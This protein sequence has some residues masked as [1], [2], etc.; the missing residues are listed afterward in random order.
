[1]NLSTCGRSIES[2]KC[3]EAPLSTIRE[4]QVPPLQLDDA[5]NTFFGG[6]GLLPVRG[7][8]SDGSHVAGESDVFGGCGVPPGVTVE[9]P[10]GI[11]FAS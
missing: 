6:F 8:A 4:N 2:R 11:A 10:D 5:A 1:M 9:G 3:C 7:L